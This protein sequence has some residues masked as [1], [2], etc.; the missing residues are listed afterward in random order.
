MSKHPWLT[1]LSAYRDRRMVTILFLGFSSGLPYALSFITLSVWFREVEMSRTQ[2]GLFSIVGLPYALK[3]F[4]APLIDR[5]PFPGLT[6][7]LGQRR[8]WALASQIGLMASLIWLGSLQPET[9]LGLMA[10][11]ALVV[12]FM[13]ASQDI[14]VDAYRIE[15]LERAEQTIGGAMYQYG[16]RFDMLASGAGA[17]RHPSSR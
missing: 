14:V 13:S 11:A 12:V 17:P 16:Y 15:T 8:G 7:R 9:E 4:W 6:R 3:L 10:I 1:A 2:I 5:V